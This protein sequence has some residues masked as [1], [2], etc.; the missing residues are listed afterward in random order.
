MFPLGKGLLMAS[1]GSDGS[2]IAKAQGL[3]IDSPPESQGNGV[4][5]FFKEGLTSQTHKGNVI[6]K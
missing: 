1:P 2:P 6:T 5:E 4:E 3:L